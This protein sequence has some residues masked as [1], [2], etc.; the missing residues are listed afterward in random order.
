M[1]TFHPETLHHNPAV[2]QQI[3]RNFEGKLGWNA[4]VIHPGPIAVRDTAELLELTAR[5]LTG[6]S[7]RSASPTAIQQ[8]HQ[9]DDKNDPK[10][11]HNSIVK[12]KRRSLRDSKRLRR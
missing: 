11:F 12:R 8:Q 2:L 1:T 6:P 5:A 9:R 4:S 3:Y 10:Y 7:G